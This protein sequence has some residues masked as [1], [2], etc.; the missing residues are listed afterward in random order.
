MLTCAQFLESFANKHVSSSEDRLEETKRRK[1]ARKSE[2]LVE[3]M[4]VSGVLTASGYEER[5][6]FSE[7]EIVDRGANDKGLLVNMP[8]GNAINGWDV[9]V[10][11]VRVTSVKRTVRYHPHAEFILRVRRDG[12][13]DFHVAR[14]YGDFVKLHKRLRTEFPGK[15]LPSLPRKNKSST[16]SSWFGSADDD[17]SSISSASTQDAN[18][19]TTG[20]T[21]APGGPDLKHSS[22]RSSMRSS[23]SP[24]AS[25]EI[26]RDAVLYREEQR[27][28]LRAFLRTL[29]Q[30]KRVAESRSMEE[31]LTAMP[32]TLNEEEM[33]DVQRRKEMDAV[34]I[35]EQKRFY[36]IARQRAAELDVYMEKFR[37]DIV[38]S[39]KSSRVAV[40]ED[41]MLIYTHR[42]IDQAFRGDPKEI[43][44]CRAQPAVPEVCRMA[45]HRSC[46]HCVPLVPC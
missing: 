36:E 27:V 28:S 31:F 35:E 30:N 5:I 20:R 11:A 33:A 23:K 42:W 25:D 32:V 3:L 34:R 29:L 15:H 18:V 6:Q 8:E 44:H 4:M 17:N 26:S 43:L 38:E 16:Y 24:R 7:M 10:A 37:R 9:N 14:R 21:L 1:L 12:K 40:S 22:S 41:A 45:S 19:S 46:C 2:K 39:S 13:E